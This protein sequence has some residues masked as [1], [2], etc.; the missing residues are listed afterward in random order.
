LL[1]TVGDD[2]D[3]EALKSGDELAGN[4]EDFNLEQQ[5]ECNGIDLDELL[6]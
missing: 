2:W 1:W 4:W 3:V 5:L 6:E